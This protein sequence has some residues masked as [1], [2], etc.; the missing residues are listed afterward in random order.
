VVQRLAVQLAYSALSEPHFGHGA[1]VAILME[2]YKGIL[3]PL[4]STYLNFQ[5]VAELVSAIESSNSRRR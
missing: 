3:K 2:W 4:P 5:L 1:L